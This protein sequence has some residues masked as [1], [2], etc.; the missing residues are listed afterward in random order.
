MQHKVLG[1]TL[2]WGLCI[3][4]A[5]SCSE[6]DGLSGLRESGG[7]QIQGR[8][9]PQKLQTS[10]KVKACFDTEGMSAQ[11]QSEL[12]PKLSAK[13][14]KEIVQRTGRVI[15]MF[16]PGST[17]LPLCNASSEHQIR[18]SVLDY[19]LVSKRA[20]KQ[21]GRAFTTGIHISGCSKIRSQERASLTYTA[22]GS[23][24]RS[25]SCIV[26]F[27]S[28][29]RSRSVSSDKFLGRA[30]STLLHELLHSYGIAHEHD[31]ADNRARVAA[32]QSTTGVCDPKTFDVS[33]GKL[34]SAVDSGPYDPDSI[35]NYCSPAN[36]GGYGAG[37]DAVRLSNGDVNLLLK[38]YGNDTNNI[39]AASVP[40]PTA[41]A[42]TNRA[43]SPA[44]RAPAA[45]V[46][47]SSNANTRLEACSHNTPV[48]FSDGW[49]TTYVLARR[50]A[51]WTTT[52][53]AQSRRDNSAMSWGTYNVATDRDSQ[54]K[55]LTFVQN[56]QRVLV[57]NTPTGTQLTIPMDCAE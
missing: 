23:N 6:K 15:D 27:S 8:Y 2:G 24:N 16:P 57:H 31:H 17:A 36:G 46:P 51:G 3:L 44:A 7:S 39:P 43:P 53:T 28:T 55:F 49:H 5:T 11:D 30:A 56:G 18:I 48:I 50:A 12:I 47:P 41:V 26:L 38:L 34:G 35:M 1:R 45:S 40:A 54:E 14:H 33:F 19:E 10:G 52:V 9:E 22:E 32:G 20:A 21:V 37:L 13:V 29:M 25:Q 42:N 4:A